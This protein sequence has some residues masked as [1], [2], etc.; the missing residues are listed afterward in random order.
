MVLTHAA[1]LWTLKIGAIGTL[2]VEW[3][4]AAIK[5]THAMALSKGLADVYDLEA[6][7]RKRTHEAP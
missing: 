6:C 1:T 2:A 4:G 3:R 7:L 5:V